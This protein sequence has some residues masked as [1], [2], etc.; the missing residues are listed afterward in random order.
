[1]LF[2]QLVSLMEEMEKG[3][4][5]MATKTVRAYTVDAE[6]TTLH[7]KKGYAQ[8]GSMYEE[9]DLE[10]E[11]GIE[12]QFDED[13]EEDEEYTPAMDDSV[14]LYLKEIGTFPLLTA[15]Q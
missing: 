9:S 2:D 11:L 15:E 8:Q 12:D 13:L 3:V 10:L 1:M 14:K 5:E 7:G 4:S 6:A